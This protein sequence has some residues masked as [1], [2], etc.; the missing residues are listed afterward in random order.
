[1]PA[2]GTGGR[3]ARQPRKPVAPTVNTFRKYARYIIL[4]ILFGMLIVSFALW[5]IGD[6]LRG[7][8]GLVVGVANENSIAFGCAS[9]LRAFGAEGIA[10]RIRHHC[11]LASQFAGWVREAPEWEVAAP[12]PFS[13]ICFR[14]VRPGEGV[15]ATNARNARI[16][17]R[18]N[19]SGDIFISHTML[20]PTYVIRVA[21][22]NLGTEERHIR[23]AWD[24]LQAAARAG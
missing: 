4:F 11:A 18:V 19:E 21:L 15:E 10:T 7:K 1:M 14:H 12:H 20:G 6:M 2:H 9:K 8:R 3:H 13:T 24:L 16:L 22:G 17:D 23:R 5:G